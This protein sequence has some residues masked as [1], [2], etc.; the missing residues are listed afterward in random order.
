VH[1]PK[2]LEV[3]AWIAGL[4]AAGA[5]HV[6]SRFAMGRSWAYSRLSQLVAGGLLEQRTLLHRQPGLYIATA[7]GLRWCGKQRLGVYRVGPGG[8]QHAW[9][10]AR[11]AAALEPHLGDGR[12]LSERELRA[13]E[14]SE[15]RVV[16]S[17][18][19]G[20]LPGGRPALHRPDL[21]ITRP[22]ELALAIEVELSIKAPRRLAAICRSWA[23]AREV[24]HVYY[25]ADGATARSVAR[26]VAEVRGEGRIT[27]LPLD[28]PAAVLSGET[29]GVL[30]VTR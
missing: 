28:D 17:A 4:G 29:K 26:A 6:M 24:A 12:V 23:R 27:I 2:D 7:E 10:V 8:F 9:E 11:V 14:A 13:L 20:Q 25:L 18:T 5:E 19:A 1:T 3:V 21:V 16:A 15:D 22:D 30:H